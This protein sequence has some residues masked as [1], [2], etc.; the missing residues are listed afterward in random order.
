MMKTKSIRQTI[1]I[2]A[3]PHDVYEALMDS[4]K[5]SRLTGDRASIS[6]RPHGRISAHDGHI[7][8]TNLEIVP[9]KR[10]VQEWRSDE[11]CWPEGHFSRLTVSL[12]RKRTGTQ[13]RLFQSGVPERCLRTIKRGWY[14]YYW[15][16]LKKML[17]TIEV[18]L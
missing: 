12:A 18:G 2:R 8:G 5:H 15:S 10:I 1:S 13:L 14:E 11:P 17:E 4:R 3:D 9:D 7:V 6:R 16:P